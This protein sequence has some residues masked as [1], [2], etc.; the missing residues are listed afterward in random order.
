MGDPPP[1]HLQPGAFAA[2]EV[3]LALDGDAL[4]LR[5]CEPVPDLVEVGRLAGRIHR[6]LFGH[7][8]PVCLGR[9]VVGD[10]LGN[11]GMGVVYRATDPELQRDVALKVLQPAQLGDERARLRMQEEA[12]TLASLDHPNIVEIHDILVVEGQM[13][14]VMPL[15]SGRTLADWARA[16]RP[17]WRAVVEAYAQ[18][19]DGL[20]AAHSVGVVH[21]DFKPG[22]AMMLESGR[23][24][25]L[26]FGL[27]RRPSA[28]P[29][30]VPDPGA[31]APATSTDASRLTHTGAVLGTRGYAAPEQ[32]HG[33]VATPASDQFSFCASMHTALEDVVPFAGDSVEEELASIHAGRVR[34]GASDRPVPAWLR[35]LIRRGLAADPASRFPSMKALLAELRRPR[36]WPRWRV[37]VLVGGTA[38]AALTAAFTTARA[39]TGERPCDGGAASIAPVW[40]L[41]AR[42]QVAV[43]TAVVDSPALSAVRPRVLHELDAYRD[44]WQLL[45]LRACVEH[46]RSNESADLLDRRARCLAHRL[47]DLA[48]S[49]KVLRS[50]DRATATTALA[51]VTGMPSLDE[52]ADLERLGAA[53]AP[54]PPA[55]RTAVDAVRASLAYARA[56]DDGGR[57]QDALAQA[58]NA[59]ADAERIGYR[60]V[61][62]EA[63]LLH[64]RILGESESDDTGAIA[65][66]SRAQELGLELTMYS[67][68]VEAGARRVYLE[69][70]Q[71]LPAPDQD[72]MFARLATEGAMLE[73]VSRGLV[74]DAFA[75]PLLLDNLRGVETSAG[76]V[77]RADQLVAQAHQLVAGI[78]DPDVELTGIDMHF[79]MRVQDPQRRLEVLRNVWDQRRAKLGD[80]HLFTL[81]ALDIYARFDPDLP[82][83]AATMADV[84]A[85]YQQEHPEQRETRAATAGYRA[86]L[87]EQLGHPDDALALYRDVVEL[88][89]PDDP[90]PE[91][92]FRGQLAT[93]HLLRLTGDSQAAIAAYLPVATQYADGGWWTRTRAGEAELGI[94]LAQLALHRPD[95]ARPHL[96]TAAAIYD[97]A[98]TQNLKSEYPLRSTLAHSLLE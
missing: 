70:V 8:E 72:R 27:A 6:K 3:G 66:L 60:P 62:A 10:R 7:A 2:T 18:A 42:V 35:A 59:V 90:D 33:G 9:Y 95:L 85:A 65:E 15:L 89:P 14:L 22:N 4:G 63:A 26:D 39:M 96:T 47:D 46:R 68:A 24:R 86:F 43:A 31:R 34:R 58:G 45:H 32:I 30:A 74:N 11:G 12:R 23:V 75:R 41:G 93:G 87:A 69:S 19:G 20:A 5:D 29:D 88:A 53:V 50:I 77:E 91:L 56:L 76:H 92:A 52:C 21:R 73:Q 67:L 94:G 49:V 57:V 17:S 38:V 84:A 13:V 28:G 98:T 61:I 83:A 48:S 97:A 54:P 80:A 25:V 1:K 82:T 37:P 51:T 81:Q 79:G 16:T 71:T 40:G 64:G 55:Q 36:G 44:R 78:T